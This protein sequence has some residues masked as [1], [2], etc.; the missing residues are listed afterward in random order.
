MDEIKD[1][2]KLAEW[3][4]IC[5]QIEFPYIIEKLEEYKKALYQ[6]SKFKVGDRVVLVKEPVI[7]DTERWGLI[8]YKLFFKIGATAIIEEVEYQKGGFRYEFKFELGSGNTLC[9]ETFR[10]EEEYFGLYLKDEKKFTIK[11]SEFICLDKILNKDITD[12]FGGEKIGEIIN[13]GIENNAVIATFKLI[14]MDEYRSNF[15]A[16]KLENGFYKG[17]IKENGVFIEPIKATFSRIC[18]ECHR[19]I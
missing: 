13:L 17:R 6:Y 4:K 11:V 15:L 2:K 18:S 14:N 1:L 16:K 19:E 5:P 3:V 12:G 10:L 7:S 9:L 8:S